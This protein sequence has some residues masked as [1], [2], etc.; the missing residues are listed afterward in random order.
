MTGRVGLPRPPTKASMVARWSFCTA[1]DRSTPTS[2]TASMRQCS[3]TV[4]RGIFTFP[5]KCCIGGQDRGGGK[6]GRDRLGKVVQDSGVGK[7]RRG[8]AWPIDCT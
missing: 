1:R 4:N 5:S 2:H 6:S 8:L 3:R 7:A